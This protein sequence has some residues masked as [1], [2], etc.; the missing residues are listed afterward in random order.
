M[1]T[2]QTPKRQGQVCPA[3]PSHDVAPTQY[4]NLTQCVERYGFVPHPTP[5]AHT[6]TIEGPFGDEVCMI[7]YFENNSVYKLA[8]RNDQTIPNDT[9]QQTREYGCALSTLR[10]FGC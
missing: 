3:P 2:H 6:E 4:P 8:M 9:G 5:I 7:Y 10:L 1:Y